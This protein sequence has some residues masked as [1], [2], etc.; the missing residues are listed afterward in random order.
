MNED[1]Y[2]N[3]NGNCHHLTTLYTDTSVF[4]NPNLSETQMTSIQ[5]Y[6]QHVQTPKPTSFPTFV[7]DVTKPFTYHTVSSSANAHNYYVNFDNYEHG[8]YEHGNYEHGNH[9][10]QNIQENPNF[11]TSGCVKTYLCG[12]FGCLL[13]SF[14]HCKPF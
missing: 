8:N 3:R 7:K 5:M 4:F 9:G 10:N 14:Y 1:D 2:N 6:N 11:E 13:C 12:L